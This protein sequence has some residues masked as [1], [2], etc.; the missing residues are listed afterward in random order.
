MEEKE[1]VIEDV[2]VVMVVFIVAVVD[3]KLVVL[4]W[5]EVPKKTVENNI[6]L[7]LPSMLERYQMSHPKP[8]KANEVQSKKIWMC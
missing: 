5:S 6:P 1:V 7:Y 3:I 4:A 2:I 8:F